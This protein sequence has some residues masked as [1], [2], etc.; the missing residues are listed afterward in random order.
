MSRLELQRPRQA[1]GLTHELRDRLICACTDTL[2]GKRDRA[3]IAI[4]YDTLCRRA[5]LVGLRVEDLS[6]AASGRGATILILRA[7]NDP[8][9]SGRLGYVSENTCKLLD[10]WFRATNI[11]DGW[12]FRRVRG[13]KVGH[14]ALNP[15]SVNRI[16]KST[17]EAA[18]LPQ[19]IIDELSGHSNA[20]RSSPGHDLSGAERPAHNASRWVEDY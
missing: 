10:D 14:D 5:E 3:M 12:I 17:A 4:G 20:R 7:K 2:T 18:E 6:V 11:V 15:Y 16:I 19:N 8:F 13:Q 9:G 1:L